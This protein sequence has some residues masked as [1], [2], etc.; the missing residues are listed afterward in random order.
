[1]FIPATRQETESLGWDRCDI[2]LV[3]GDACVDSPF[4]GTAVIG[5][6]LMYAGYRVGIIAQPDMRDDRDIARLGEPLLFWGVSSGSVD[7][8]VANYTAT[9]KRR[10][11]DDLTPGGKN[12]RRPDRAVIAYANLIR[13]HFKDTVPIVLGG[14]EASQRRVAH[15][16]YWDDA[17][18]RSILFDAKADILVYGMGERAVLEVAERLRGGGDYRAIRGI[19][20]IA[21]EKPGSF[22]ELPSF[23]RVSAERDEFIEMSRIFFKNADPA[24]GAGMV[25]RH[26]TRYLVHNPPAAP[27]SSE[28]L[29]RIH[30]LGYEREVHPRCRKMGEVRALETVRFSIT[31]HRGC[32]G[33]CAFC[34]IATHQ[35]SAVVS[36][37]EASIL[38]EARGFTRDRRFRGIISD[39]GGPTANMYGMLC[40]RMAGK[41]ICEDRR[42]LTPHIC[43]N[44][45]MSHRSQISLLKK[46]RKIPG[47]R[48]AFIA[49]GIR[50]D[51]VMADREAGE[52]YLNEV[53]RHHVSGQLKVA[54][55]HCVDRVLDLM[56][57]PYVESLLAFRDLF[58][59]LNRQTRKK[60]FLT[61]YFIAAHPGCTFEDMS[62][63]GRF[64]AREL[65]IVPEQVQVFTPLPSTWSALMFHTGRDPFSGERL[66][67]ERSNREKERQKRAVMRRKK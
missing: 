37:S 16:D 9:G 34:S 11:R 18:R 24:G 38:A 41:G 27:L 36:R 63:L 58:S 55:E 7:S 19:C 44:M 35:G 6:V 12:T 13:R 21:T 20:H 31:T 59:R 1:M 52:E 23:E 22:I 50:H 62:E 33:G 5:R 56:G 42:C 15:F 4:M 54:P 43:R 40:R 3:S 47:V 28:E 53:V 17:I 57:K 26:G 48:K 65:Q 30:G 46:I 61:Y 64:V 51:L 67:V 49:S 10:M 8:M 45:G 60:Q 29:D 66:F 25:Q 14:I 39:I 32:F 2:I